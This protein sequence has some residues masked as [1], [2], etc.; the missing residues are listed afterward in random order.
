M[1][2]SVSIDKAK[3][4]QSHLDQVKTLIIQTVE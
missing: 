2:T 1:T 4:L 3:D